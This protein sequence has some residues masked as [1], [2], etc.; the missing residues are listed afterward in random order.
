MMI[1]FAST[2]P[3]SLSLSLSLSRCGSVVLDFMMRFNQSVVVNNILTVLS[4]AAR[5]NKL[6]GFKVNPASIKQVFLPSDGSESTVKG[7]FNKEIVNYIEVRKAT[8]CII[9]HGFMLLWFK[10]WMNE[11]TTSNSFDEKE[12]ATGLQL[13]LTFRVLRDPSRELLIATTLKFLKN[14][15]RLCGIFLPNLRILSQMNN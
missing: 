8:R 2:T 12:L 15:F 1:F 14:L 9:R 5:Q 10:D 7:K 11:V 13:F 3:P 6:G 4:N